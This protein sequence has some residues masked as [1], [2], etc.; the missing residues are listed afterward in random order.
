MP[1]ENTP[2]FYSVI[3]EFQKK[4]AKL[5]GINVEDCS[6]L[7]EH[8]DFSFNDDQEKVLFDGS[9]AVETVSWLDSISPFREYEIKKRRYK[10]YEFVSFSH[11]NELLSGCY[12]KMIATKKDV[13]ARLL[14]SINKSGKKLEKP[15]L[16]DKD[17]EATIGEIITFMKNRKK[18]KEAGITANKGLLIWGSP[19]NGKT[20]I[21]SYIM[22]WCEERNYEVS[23]VTKDN[24]V[25]KLKGDVLIFDDFSIDD[26]VKRT[27]TTD[28]LLSAMDGPN[29][30]GGRVYLFT[31]NELNKASELYGALVRPGRIDTIVKL[32]KP[33]K[34][35]RLKYISSWKIKLS[36]EDCE[37]IAK[38]SDGWSFA[39][40]NYL[41]TEIVLRKIQGKSL[42]IKDCFALCI[43]K[44]GDFEDQRKALGFLSNQSS[45]LGMGDW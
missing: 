3:A 13:L 23:I 17:Y 21:S 1:I 15:I 33:S 27:D 4:A 42:D 37:K 36:E 44:Y 2:L 10:N 5:L 19:G 35:L 7:V 14:L 43:S 16:E 45:G 29:K 20:L 9:Y 41:H 31:T 24:L 34:A 38:N 39:Q 12:F 40:L 26:L 30:E 25:K 32:G 18:I 11:Y 8:K 6:F 28:I 22:E